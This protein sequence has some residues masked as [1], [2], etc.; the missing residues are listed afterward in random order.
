MSGPR[1]AEVLNKAFF[2]FNSG[3]GLQVRLVDESGLAYTAS[4][5][6]HVDTE[7]ILN[8]GSVIVSD[9]TLAGLSF[10]GHNQV[11][12]SGNVTQIIAA[13]SDRK[14]VQISASGTDVF[15]GSG[16]NVSTSNGY[17]LED[18]DKVSISTFSA[19]HGVT[20][21]STV[22]MFYLEVS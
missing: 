14:E 6:L 18:G 20:A 11:S 13:D 7:I 22:T 19:I 16:T 9:V 1:A 2:G 17:L 12:F 8:A 4:N 21:G 5:P 10:S 3:S 15:I